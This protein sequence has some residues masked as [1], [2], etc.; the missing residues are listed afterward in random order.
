M[1]LANLK[2]RSLLEIRRSARAVVAAW[3]RARARPTAVEQTML[4]ILLQPLR[5]LADGLGLSPVGAFIVIGTLVFGAFA[6]W[7]F[8]HAHHGPHDHDDD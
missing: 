8:Q 4:D 5:V 1:R 6:Q 2:I 7:R 3:P